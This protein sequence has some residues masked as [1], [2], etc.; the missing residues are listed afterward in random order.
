MTDASEGDSGDGDSGRDLRGADQANPWGLSSVNTG[1]SNI[2]HMSNGQWTL[3]GQYGVLKL[4]IVGGYTYTPNAGVA[5]GA[6]D[7]FNYYLKDNDGTPPVSGKLTITFTG[8][9]GSGGSG[10][11]TIVSPGPNSTLAGGAGAD[12]ITASQGGDVITGG[13]GGD[14]FVFNK[15]PWSPHTVKDFHVGEDKLDLSALLQAARYTGSDPVAD[16]YVWLTDD[17]AGGLNVLFDWDGTGPNPQWPNFVAK[18][19]GVSASTTTWAQLTGGGTGGGSEPPPPP[20][21]PGD[22]QVITSP[23]PGSTLTGGA[24]A[25]T[26]VSSRGQDTLTGAGGA[27]HFRFVD[28]N[29]AP[30]TITDFKAAEGDKIDLRGVFDDWGYAGAIPFA[31]GRLILQGDGQG[32]TLVLLDDDGPGGDW[33]NYVLLVRGVG[34]EVMQNAGNW[35]FQ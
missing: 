22:G 10:G 28:E 29:W 26:L 12:T 27:D 23:G 4:D 24:G 19:E 2:G 9:G 33:P 7:T 6:V 1:A 8:D 25:D 16:K 15:N 13:A 17:G 21:P 35:I 11:Q 14:W 5:A 3:A 34:L 30:A 20:P 31:D 32:S 18:L